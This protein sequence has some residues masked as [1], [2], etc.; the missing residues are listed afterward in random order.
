VIVDQV[1]AVMSRVAEPCA[2]LVQR[3]R[4]SKECGFHGGEIDSKARLF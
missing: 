4:L 1:L 3:A 2:E